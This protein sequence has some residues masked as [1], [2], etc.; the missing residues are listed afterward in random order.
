V[1]R[2]LTGL[3]IVAIDV[4]DNSCVTLVICIVAVAAA[5]ATADANITL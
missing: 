4:P 5:A 1:V 2:T 3:L